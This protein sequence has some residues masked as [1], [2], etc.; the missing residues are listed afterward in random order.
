MF[1]GEGDYYKNRSSYGIGGPNQEFVL[2]V[3][4]YL[5]DLENNIGRVG[6]DIDETDGPTNFAGALMDKYSIIKAKKLEIFFKKS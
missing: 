1:N 2:S 4:I 3:C 5:E 6:I